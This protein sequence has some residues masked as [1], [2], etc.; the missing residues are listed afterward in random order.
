M[1]VKLNVQEFVKDYCEGIQDRELLARHNITAKEMVGIVKKLINDGAITKEQYFGRNKKIRE[2]EARQEKAFLQSLYHCPVC[3]H[4]QPSPFNRCPACG[5]DISELRQDE[6]LTAEVAAAA[7]SDTVVDDLIARAEPEAPSEEPEKVSARVAEVPEAVRRYLGMFLQEV[8]AL[9]GAPD[10]IAH[11][12]YEIDEI[13]CHDAQSTLFRATPDVKGAPPVTVKLF[14]PELMPAD[15]MDEALSRI[16]SYQSAMDDVN[17]VNIYGSGSLAGHTILIYEHL[18]VNLE[19]ML[20]TETEGVPDDLLM[21]M[22]PQILNAVGYSHMHRGT[23]GI[24][25]RL[26]HM[27]LRVSRLFFDPGTKIVK[28]EGCGVWRAFVEVRGHKRHL[29]EEP[30][31]DMAAMAPEAFVLESKFV[32]AYHADMYAVGALLYRL[33]TGEPPFS[34]SSP[35]D[36][37]FAHLRKFPVPPK[38]HRYTIPAWLDSLILKCL[39]K[40]PGR[41]WRSATQMELSI[42]KDIAV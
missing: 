36:Y 27:N 15:L 11:F 24:I 25:R 32:H 6:A 28:L 12:D 41:R 29:W 35:K 16:I 19:K 38:V 20:E 22:L 31:V 2:A 5:T 1:G 8:S 13:I 42:G 14:E 33:A 40:E 26:P 30:G 18:P 10:E 17:I 21:V 4:I 7:A 9:A 39:E 23:D 34:A 37:G 3:S